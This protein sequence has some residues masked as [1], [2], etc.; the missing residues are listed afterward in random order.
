[1]ISLMSQKVST[2]KAAMTIP[3]CPYAPIQDDRVAYGNQHPQRVALF[4]A[5]CTITTSYSATYTL[6]AKCT[7]ENTSVIDNI[8]RVQLC[9]QQC[10]TVFN[11]VYTTQKEYSLYFGWSSCQLNMCIQSYTCKQQHC[12]T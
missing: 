5:H 4:T 2:L 7:R 6:D 12:I 11:C 8:H 9:V 1:M 3:V 10:S